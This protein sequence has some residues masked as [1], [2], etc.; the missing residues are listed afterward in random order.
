MPADMIRCDQEMLPLPETDSLTVIEFEASE[1][2]NIDNAEVSL[3][4]NRLKKLV[5][6]GLVAGLVAC[7]SARHDTSPQTIT[8]P[9]IITDS[10]PSSTIAMAPTTA[11]SPVPALPANPE[12]YLYAGVASNVEGNGISALLDQ[13][14]PSLGIDGE[15]SLMEISAETS[16]GKQIVEVGW[17][18]ENDVSEKTLPR[19][20]VYHWV[21]GK[22]TCY[23]SCGFVSTSSQIKPGSVV[24]P[25]TK[26]YYSIEQKNNQWQ[27]FYD[28]KELGYFPD[29]LWK[30]EFK[31]TG[32]VQA[33]GEVVSKDNSPCIQMGNGKFGSDV[34]SAKISNIGIP[35]SSE[36]PILVP[37]NKSSFLY[38]VRIDAVAEASLGGPGYCK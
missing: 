28:G 2:I 20:F 37:Y 4:Q 12:H 23:D 31:S 13:E 26:G 34:G 25:K 35:G 22:S 5:V 27:I 29:S 36:Q 10:L 16:D 8:V 7:G 38:N 9:T 11:D 21:N 30:N 17:T 33:F 6:L 24:Q 19:L 18:V 32:L 15:H 3:R 14:S 1:Q